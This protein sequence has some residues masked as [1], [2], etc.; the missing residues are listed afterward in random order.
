MIRRI[1][2]VFL[3]AA[4]LGG[5][6]LRAAEGRFAL[7]VRIEMG[8]AGPARG[9]AVRTELVSRLGAWAGR[10][11]RVVGSCVEVE[12]SAGSGEELAAALSALARAARKAGLGFRILPTAGAELRALA[13][14]PVSVDPPRRSSGG[15]APAAL[16]PPGR[17]WAAARARAQAARPPVMAASAVPA[18]S[19]PRAPPA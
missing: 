4:L 12:L 7:K 16:A 2:G 18:S 1:Q 13:R 8:P 19:A 9:A 6:P 14:A 5:H 10:R 11:L 15:P 17:P 3:I